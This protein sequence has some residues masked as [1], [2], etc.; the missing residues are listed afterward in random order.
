MVS[1]SLYLSPTEPCCL[2]ESRSLSVPSPAANTTTEP[3]YD[4]VVCMC[5]LVDIMVTHTQGKMGSSVEL[6][7]YS[8]NTP[9]CNI[10]ITKYSSILYVYKVLAHYA[11]TIFTLTLSD[12][13]LLTL[14]DDNQGQ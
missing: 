10:T 2:S 8:L 5:V 14:Q 12:T 13:P 3:Q 1:V 6:L 9:A 7:L 4:S 11:C